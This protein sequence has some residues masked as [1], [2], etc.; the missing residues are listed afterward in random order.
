V[1]IRGFSTPRKFRSPERYHSGVSHGRDLTGPQEWLLHYLQDYITHHGYPPTT[2]DIQEAGPW[3]STS[4]ILYQLNQLQEKNRI[5]R[6]PGARMIQIVGTPENHGTVTVHGS[7]CDLITV[8]GHITTQFPAPRTWVILAFSD[9]T[10]LHLTHTTTAWVIQPLQ[11]GTGD[12]RILRASELDNAGHTD[13]AW[14]T[15]DITWVVTGHLIAT[16]QPGQK[17]NPAHDN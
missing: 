17:R 6:G 11:H 16:H 15:G 5:I 14:L 4:S 10:V 7:G 2:R 3:N 1:R 13:Q 8:E 9:G 12:L